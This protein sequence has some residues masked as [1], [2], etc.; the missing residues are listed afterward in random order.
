M[1]S[2]SIG[3]PWW[4]SGKESACQVGDTGLILGSGRS[5]GERNGNPL[6]YSCLGNPMD[7]GAWWATVHGVE[8]E[9]DTTSCLPPHCLVLGVEG[10]K[11]SSTNTLFPSPDPAGFYVSYSTKKWQSRHKNEKAGKSPEG[12]GSRK[13]FHMWAF[14]V[15]SVCMVHCI[16]IAEWI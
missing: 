9:S 1:D 14:G 5:P 15:K 10:Q 12:L 16:K 13:H 2:H 3:L 8:K 4:L 7:R 11:S 6:Q